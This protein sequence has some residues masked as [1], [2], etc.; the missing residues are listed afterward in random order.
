MENKKVQNI[1]NIPNIDD[2]KQ[3]KNSLVDIVNEDFLDE[4]EDNESDWQTSSASAGDNAKFFNANEYH[5]YIISVNDLKKH[6]NSKGNFLKS[7]NK[8]IQTLADN[9]HN[10]KKT[11]VILC[12][13]KRM[14]NDDKKRQTMKENIIVRDKKREQK[15]FVDITLLTPENIAML[16]NYVRR[17]MQEYEAIVEK[18][19][20]DKMREFQNMKDQKVAELKNMKEQKIAELQGLKQEK[21]SGAIANIKS[22]MNT[23]FS[24]I[25]TP[26]TQQLNSFL[27]NV[28]SINIPVD[29]NIDT[30]IDFDS[31]IRGAALSLLK[32]AV[33]SGILGKSNQI[34]I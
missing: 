4:K 20:A 34:E 5:Q 7:D 23:F 15:I 33:A 28:N 13:V 18:M 24:L 12:N 11:K 30:T 9:F 21:I 17:A 32:S 29:I 25:K 8:G 6:A 10:D 27:D 3:F 26:P 16:T 22:L 14:I 2:L 19:K 1:Q 31:L